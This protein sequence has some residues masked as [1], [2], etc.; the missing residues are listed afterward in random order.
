MQ[1]RVRRDDAD[2]E[3]APL[4]SERLDGYWRLLLIAP[5]VALASDAFL[6]N[7]GW[8]WQMARV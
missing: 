3:W 6:A 5:A 1:V 4:P 2:S 8:A 7:S